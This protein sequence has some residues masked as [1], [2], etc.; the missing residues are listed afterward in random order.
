MSAT[1]SNVEDLGGDVLLEVGGQLLRV[2]KGLLSFASP[3]FKALFSPKWSEGAKA[4]AGE[5]VRLEGDNMVIGMMLFRILH[6]QWPF[7][8]A[9]GSQQ[10]IRLATMADKYDCI[11][12]IRMPVR[13]FLS[14]PHHDPAGLGT[15]DFVRLTSV[16]ATFDIPEGFRR[17]TKA[18]IIDATEPITGPFPDN[19]PAEI[20]GEQALTLQLGSKRLVSLASEL[21]RR[22]CPGT[23]NDPCDQT[24]MWLA[25]RVR[26][27][28]VVVMDMEIRPALDI[29]ANIEKQTIAQVLAQAHLVAG[30]PESAPVC[31]A[32]DRTI[33]MTKVEY[34][35]I[36]DDIV[37]QTEG[38]CLDCVNGPM[39]GT[40]MVHCRIPHA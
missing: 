16:A 28:P 2:S 21:S 9:P 19:L 7:D 34:R 18:L 20:W 24:S 32:H 25:D 3:Y 4:N 5:P 13:W 10:L 33:T 35:R 38:L 6:M 40:W 12:A 11:K 14:P 37:R 31:R 17:F 22:T 15:S 29:F 30:L 26:N 39:P 23:A 27:A 36:L 1:S 8:R